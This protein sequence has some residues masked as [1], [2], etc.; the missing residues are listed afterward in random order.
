MID[1]LRLLIELISIILVI[2][3]VP[4]IALS[5]YDIIMLRGIRRKNKR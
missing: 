2:I 4:V 3:A 5:I 1:I